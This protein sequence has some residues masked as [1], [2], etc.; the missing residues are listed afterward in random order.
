MPLQAL[1]FQPGVRRNATTLSNEGSWFECDKVR[2]R[3]GLPEKLVV[4]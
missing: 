1:K 3:G 2:F 4:G